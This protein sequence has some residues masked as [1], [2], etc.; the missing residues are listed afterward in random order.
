MASESGAQRSLK[1][2]WSVA[3]KERNKNVRVCGKQGELLVF[4]RSFVDTLIRLDEMFIDTWMSCVPGSVGAQCGRGS[5]FAPT[6]LGLVRQRCGYKHS[7][8]TELTFAANIRAV[9]ILI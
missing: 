1:L 7:A 3:R 4:E 2:R 5:Y 9:L 6:E 8:P